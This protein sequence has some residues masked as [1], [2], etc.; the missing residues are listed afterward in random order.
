VFIL[1]IKLV[2]G[3]GHHV[4][5]DK[6]ELFNNYVN[7]IVELIDAHD[8]TD[9]SYPESVNSIQESMHNHDL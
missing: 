8:E 9:Q 7:E 5:A 3:A 1:L 2:S 4:Y 6:P